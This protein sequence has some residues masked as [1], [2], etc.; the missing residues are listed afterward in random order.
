[1]NDI[2]DEKNTNG[3]YDASKITVLEGLAQYESAQVC[4]SAVLA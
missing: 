4:I 3:S 1:M 2:K